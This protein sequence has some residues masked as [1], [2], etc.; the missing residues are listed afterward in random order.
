MKIL[1]DGLPEAI[2]KAIVNYS[3][4]YDGNI[5]N[6]VSVTT[7]ID[8][9]R[10]GYY[11]LKYKDLEINASD[12]LWKL[13]GNAMH[14]VLEKSGSSLV[15]ELRLKTKIN[16]VW[17][18]GKC[19]VYDV[20]NASI[21]DYKFTG[22]TQIANY[23]KKEHKLQLNV[24]AYIFKKN[25]LPVNKLKLHYIWRNLT[26]FDLKKDN[27]PDNF[28]S[29]YEVDIMDNIEEYIYEK[30]K[31]FNFDDDNI[32]ECSLEDR[33][34]YIK[35][36]LYNEVKYKENKY[37]KAIKVFNSKKEA[38]EYASSLKGNGTYIIK[39][40]AEETKRCDGYCVFNVICSQYKKLKESK[41]DEKYENT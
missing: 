13:L 8:S 18:H 17:L 10:I 3:D 20:E 41:E 35:W 26:N 15:K 5:E 1:N 25:N 37:N 34:G 36:K 29:T 24:L 19:D 9:P 32:P 27:F 7:L 4:E 31:L 12:E 14:A 6:S 28:I 30:I 39:K 21:E 23:P 2:Y 22:Y 11:K 16:D 38:I 40:T 33:W